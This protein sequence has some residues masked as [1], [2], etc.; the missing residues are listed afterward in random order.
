MS[1]NDWTHSGGPAQRNGQL[2]NE[3]LRKFLVLQESHSRFVDCV[4]LVAH[5]LA[6]SHVAAASVPADM[7]QLSWPTRPTLKGWQKVPVCKPKAGM[8]SRL[9]FVWSLGQSSLSKSDTGS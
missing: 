4:D 3:T 5:N 7:K 1:F 8:L 6:L 9:E 2:E